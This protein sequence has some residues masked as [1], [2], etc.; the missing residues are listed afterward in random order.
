MKQGL[1]LKQLEKEIKQLKKQKNPQNI[2]SG[3]LMGLAE[4][5]GIFGVIKLGQS[6]SK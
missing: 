2:L 3:D 5:A 1:K 6:L 4:I